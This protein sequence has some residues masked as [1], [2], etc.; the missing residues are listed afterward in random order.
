MKHYVLKPKYYLLALCVGDVRTL[1]RGDRSAHNLLIHETVQSV[2]HPGA[3]R[4]LIVEVV[5]GDGVAGH[6]GHGHGDGLDQ[7]AALLPGHVPTV[8]L[9][10]GPDLLANVVDGPQGGAVLLGDVPA[11]IHCLVVVLYHHLFGAVLQVHGVYLHQ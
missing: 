1:L 6:L 5:D 11:L 3:G 7:G 4:V 8:I 9:V 2:R 10:T